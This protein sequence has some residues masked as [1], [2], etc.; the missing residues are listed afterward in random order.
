MEVRGERSYW[1]LQ[2][3]HGKGTKQDRR[4]ME[5]SLTWWWGVVSA[6]LRNAFFTCCM[7]MWMKQ[8]VE[9]LWGWGSGGGNADWSSPSLP[10][11][12]LCI[13]PQ[14]TP[15]ISWLQPCHPLFTFLLYHRCYALFFFSFSFFLLW[16]HVLDHDVF[17]VVLY[18][19]QWHWQLFSDSVNYLF[20]TDFSKDFRRKFNTSVPHFSYL[21]CRPRLYMQA[22]DWLNISHVKHAS[23]SKLKHTKLGRSI[24]S[25]IP[26][27]L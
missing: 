5:W 16:L 27:A 21:C 24:F 9:Q 2:A 4:G 17:F 12:C 25:G 13:F 6:H 14:P 3:E 1:W 11:I 18:F 19:L 26:L 22:A 23:A 8:M 10:N 7:R 15:A 20:I